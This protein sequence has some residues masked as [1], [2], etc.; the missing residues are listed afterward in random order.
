MIEFHHIH[1]RE[2]NV[3]LNHA[4]TIPL[5]PTHHKLI[6]HPDATSGQHAIKH[7]GSLSVVQVCNTNTGYAVIFN[8]AVGAEITVCIDTKDTVSADIYAATWNIVGGIRERKCEDEVDAD[9]ERTVDR[10]GYA[11]RGSTVYFSREYRSAAYA[12]LAQWVVGY[13]TRCKAE[14]ESVLTRARND[15]RKII[16][17]SKCESVE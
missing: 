5:C 12:A 10:L 17:V 15:Y 3:G 6:Y 1:P 13:M 8:D 4:V 2:L 7:A 11:V 9:T 14:Y 16:K